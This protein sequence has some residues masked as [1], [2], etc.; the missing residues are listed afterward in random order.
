[1]QKKGR[2]LC[3]IWWREK[4]P[5]WWEGKGATAYSILCICTVYYT[6]M[7]LFTQLY[8]PLACN[9]I[10][11]NTSAR[12]GRV[13]PPTLASLIYSKIYF[14]LLHLACI[15]YTYIP[16][17]LA[18]LYTLYFKRTYCYSLHNYILLLRIPV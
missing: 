17:A 18:S 5:R 15:L 7:L 1:M 8:P 9:C 6:D 13:L 14:L 11:Q 2:H 10:S 16:P 3:W 4:F 12:N